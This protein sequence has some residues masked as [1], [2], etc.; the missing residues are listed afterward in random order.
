MTE[1]AVE[2]GS[3]LKGDLGG[4]H[5]IYSWDGGFVA[6]TTDRSV[7]DDVV[8]VMDDDAWSMTREHSRRGIVVGISSGAAAF[9]AIK[10]A[11]LDRY[12][13]LR[14]AT[15]FPDSAERYISVLSA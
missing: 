13:G 5:K 12:A 7:I 8:Q 11:A 10:I 15:I 1:A 6:P 4:V 2:V 9:A 3:H 14:I